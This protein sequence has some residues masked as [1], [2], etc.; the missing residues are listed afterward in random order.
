MNE[1]VYFVVVRDIS[2]F[3]VVHDHGNSNIPKIAFL[4]PSFPS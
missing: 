4:F 3:Y 2:S 1:T